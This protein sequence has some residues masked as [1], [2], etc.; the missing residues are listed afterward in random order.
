MFCK[1]PG[2]SIC[3]NPPGTLMSLTM[4]SCPVET[5]TCNTG[6]CIPLANK[7]NSK[8]DCEDESDESQCTY[9]EVPSNYAGQLSPSSKGSSAVPVYLNISILALPR[10]DTILL[11]FTADYYINLR[12]SQN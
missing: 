7:C 3:W 10:I 9:L 6:A 11:S 12:W 8:I 2:A 5:F 1:G 4:S